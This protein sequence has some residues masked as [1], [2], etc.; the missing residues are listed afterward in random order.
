MILENEIGSTR[1]P[2][3]ENCF[4]GGYGPVVRQTA[5]WMAWLYEVIIV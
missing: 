3:V 2:S 4:R 5:E 1:S